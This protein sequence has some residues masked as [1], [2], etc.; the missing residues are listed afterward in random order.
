MPLNGSSMQR[1]LRRRFLSLLKNSRHPLHRVARTGPA[2][3]SIY[4]SC[5]VTYV[6]G[7]GL[8]SFPIGY[9]DILSVLFTL[10]HQYLD[11]CPQ[12][13]T[14]HT[15]H[16]SL[17][18]NVAAAR[19]TFIFLGL[20]HHHDMS[21]L[22]FILCCPPLHSVAESTGDRSVVGTIHRTALREVTELYDTAPPCHR[23]LR[24]IRHQKP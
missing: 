10:P 24:L 3:P 9:L 2:V 21:Y 15:W 17:P 5:V 8:T 7:M 4:P 22:R 18:I 12:D 23:Q 1:S 19:A 11:T 14:H 6:T 16:S 13:T 20:Q